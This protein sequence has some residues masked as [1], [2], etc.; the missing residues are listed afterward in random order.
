MGELFERKMHELMRRGD[1][2]KVAFLKSLE[3][4]MLPSQIE[5]IQGNDRSVLKELVVPRWVS[6]DLLYDW[7]ISKKRRKGRRCILCS[8]LNEVGID[9]KEKFICEHCFLKLKNLD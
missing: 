8:E 4:N 6:W 3:K 5:R 9:F 2:E 7:A 1:K